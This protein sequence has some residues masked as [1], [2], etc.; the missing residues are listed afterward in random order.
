MQNDCGINFKQGNQGISFKEII[1]NKR[2]E[3]HEGII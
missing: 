1:S 3:L 2:S